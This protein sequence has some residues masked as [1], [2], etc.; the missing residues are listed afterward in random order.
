MF[1]IGHRCLQTHIQDSKS[2]GSGV[3]LNISSRGGRYGYTVP[4]LLRPEP[5]VEV[6][7]DQTMSDVNLMNTE[8]SY[9]RKLPIYHTRQK[10]QEMQV[11][12][13]VAGWVM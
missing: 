7:A 6:L 9:S 12:V 1:G 4:I 13:R 8:I 2:Y 3:V 10:Q 11:T 5:I